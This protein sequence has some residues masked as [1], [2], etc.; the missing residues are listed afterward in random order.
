MFHCDVYWCKFETNYRGSLVSHK[1]NIHD[2]NVR[3]FECEL[4]NH[5]AKTKFNLQKHI[6]N[7]HNQ[8]AILFQCVH[9]P[10]TAK[11]KTYL[12]DHYL[13]IHHMEMPE[14]KVEIKLPDDCKHLPIEGYEGEYEI[15]E[16]GQVFSLKSN[17]FMKQ[18]NNSDGYRVDLCHD[19]VKT[20]QIHRLVASAFLANPENKP[21]VVH[22][23]GNRSNNNAQNL[24]WATHS[25]KK[26]GK[27]KDGS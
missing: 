14:E 18:R 4:C 26:N 13:R 10:Q 9:C 1:R 17:M 12:K 8:N 7:I 21:F 19:G 20:H 25:E 2:I 24:R 15:Y 27:C 16:N 5:K 3:W 22:I 11:S 6:N 23:D